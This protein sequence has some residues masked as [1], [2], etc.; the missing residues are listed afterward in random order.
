MKRRT[1]DPRLAL[2]RLAEHGG[3]EVA[4]AAGGGYIMYHKGTRARVRFSPTSAPMS[5]KKCLA[6]LVL[7]AQWGHRCG[8]WSMDRDKVRDVIRLTRITSHGLVAHQEQTI[9]EVLTH[10]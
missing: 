1:K 3:V 9:R 7:T 4:K 8:G 6:R 5:A 10:A 2:E